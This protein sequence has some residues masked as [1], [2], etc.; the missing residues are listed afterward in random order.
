VRGNCAI[1]RTEEFSFFING[2]AAPLSSK[3]RTVVTE[4]PASGCQ[5]LIS[6]F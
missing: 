5:Q 4:V 3:R 2:C 6:S 1:F